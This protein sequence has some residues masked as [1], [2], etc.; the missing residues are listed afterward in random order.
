MNYFNPATEEQFKRITEFEYGKLVKNEEYIFEGYNLDTSKLFDDFYHD[1]NGYSNFLRLEES[2]KVDYIKQYFYENTIIPAV[3]DL[4]TAADTGR[5]KSELGLIQESSNELSLL[6]FSDKVKLESTARYILENFIFRDYD[7]KTRREITENVIMA[8]NLLIEEA[9]DQQ[10][11]AFA[12]G[13]DNVLDVINKL[14]PQNLIGLAR[15][16]KEGLIMGLIFFYSPY[17]LIGSANHKFRLFGRAGTSPV[18]KAINIISPCKNIGELLLKPY[19]EVG[20]LLKKVNQIEN[21]DVQNFLKGIESQSRT[22]ESIISDCWKKNAR[23]EPTENRSWLSVFQ[24]FADFIKKGRMQFLGHP[25]DSGKG[26]LGFLFSIDADDP[27]F[28]KSFFDFRKCIY[29]HIFELILGYT[30]TAMSVEITS[31]EILEKIKVASRRK[32]YDIFNSIIESPEDMDNLMYKVGKVLLGIEEIAESLK[33]NKTVLYQDKY[34]EQFYT[35]LKQKIKQTYL[36]LDEAAE[37]QR[38]VIEDNKFKDQLSKNSEEKYEESWK[39]HKMSTI[40]S[41][42]KPSKVK[43]IYD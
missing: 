36:D 29:D 32:D 42:K 6:N 30:K 19:S 37:K 41:G 16:I 2:E 12:E 23:V 26:L 5:I 1:E 27:S 10:K 40:R 9:I 39:D 3:E 31:I 15:T 24:I 28:Q 4:L 14:L 43:S 22:R 8:Q 35:Y 25:L 17:Q 11:N 38:G 18:G 13:M 33:Q 20:G 7:L 21:E 34:L